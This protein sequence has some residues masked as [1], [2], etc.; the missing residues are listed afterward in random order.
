MDLEEHGAQAGNVPML[1]DLQE[2]TR[3]IVTRILLKIAKRLQLASG[4]VLY[5]E[6]AEDTNV[7]ALL[8]EGALTVQSGDS[9]PLT[10]D[11]PDLLGEMQMLDEYGQRKATVT[12]AEDS[13]VLEFGWDDFIGVARSVLTQ[14]QQ[15]E[16]RD[17]IATHAAARLEGFSALTKD[18]SDEQE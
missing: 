2:E 4:D 6:G 14:E 7:G 9:E 18:E 17:M 16:V 5:T 3:A 8:V 10:V 11:A 12:A 13:V 1:Q 15:V